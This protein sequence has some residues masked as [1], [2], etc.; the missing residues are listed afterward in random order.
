MNIFV[1]DFKKNKPN[2]HRKK[3]HIKE[4]KRIM[5]KRNRENKMFNKLAKQHDRSS[6]PIQINQ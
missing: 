5:H 2:V 1:T 4:K 3:S 6:Q